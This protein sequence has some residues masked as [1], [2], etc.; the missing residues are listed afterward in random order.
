[1]SA[2]GESELP[3]AV[4][5]D[6]DAPPALR[7]TA[8]RC[9]SSASARMR[10][11]RALS[12]I[13]AFRQMLR[14]SRLRDRPP[15]NGSS[16]SGAARG[17]I[18]DENHGAMNASTTSSECRNVAQRVLLADV[19]AGACAASTARSSS[20]LALLARCAAAACRSNLPTN[21]PPPVDD[22]DED[23]DDKTDRPAS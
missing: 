9:E 5:G 7:S 1:M 6:D 19:V 17:R 3:T 14:M 16:T 11:S 18:D 21:S 4:L 20:F 23:D 8:S 22:D 15:T 10:S 13:S 12:S 2:G